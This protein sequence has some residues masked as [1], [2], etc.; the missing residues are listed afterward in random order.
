[1]A[2]QIFY[3]RKN[4]DK[5]QANMPDGK[6]KSR[7]GE[8]MGGVWNSQGPDEKYLKGQLRNGYWIITE[9]EYELLKTAKSKLGD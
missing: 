9:D 1:M 6:M 3:I 4:H 5:E 8:L 7:D 2:T